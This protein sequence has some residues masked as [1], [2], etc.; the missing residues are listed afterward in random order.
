[1]WYVYILRCSDNSLYI[2]ETDD[3]AARLSRHNDGRGASFTAKRRPVRL[4]FTEA[5]VSREAALERER[6][7]KRW[8]REKKE[9]LIAGDRVALKRA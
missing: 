1:V 4:V 6:Q 3:V 8:T 2:G 9:A 7:L 5:C